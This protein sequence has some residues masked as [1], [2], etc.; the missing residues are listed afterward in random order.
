LF[1]FS[2]VIWF[3]KGVDYYFNNLFFLAK[4][5]L[6]VVAGLL[7]I[8]PT[9]IYL[10]WSQA[11]AKNILPDLS[12]SNLHSLKRCIH[13]QLVIVMLV[14]FCASMMAKGFG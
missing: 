7:S 10:R 3:E 14:I 9:R 12:T 13:R 2:R 4:I 11:L 5:A 6:F 8:Y 1:G